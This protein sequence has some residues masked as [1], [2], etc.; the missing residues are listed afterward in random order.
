M[1][2]GDVDSLPAGQ[3]CAT[4]SSNWLR[5]AAL[6]ATL[7]GLLVQMLWLASVGAQPGAGK[8][9][10]AAIAT[11]AA[12]GAL[13]W[14]HRATWPH[15]SACLASLSLGG[16]GMLI[17]AE[18]DASDARACAY[19]DLGSLL[20]FST[21]FMILG[22]AVGHRLLCPPVEHGS[23]TRSVACGLACLTCMLVCMLG[24]TYWLAAPLRVVVGEA[25]A[26]GHLAM[27]VGM[28][29]GTYAGSTLVDSR[30]A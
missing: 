19:A 17:G 13:L 16:A 27:A 6:G 8:G 30:S 1:G 7:V 18:V 4:R 29:A 26:A 24:F 14:Q 22:C 25:A 10:M 15:A 9:V 3:A 2:I 12:A 11:L 20:S 28:V 21:V 5:R 23:R